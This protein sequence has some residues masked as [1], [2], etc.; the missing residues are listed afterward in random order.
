MNSCVV[1]DIAAITLEGKRR[2]NQSFSPLSVGKKWF[3][4]EVQKR[5]KHFETFKGYETKEMRDRLGLKK[6]SNKLSSDFS[7]HCVD[8]FVLANEMVGGDIIDN[9]E[10][11]CITPLI[12]ER[13]NLH[14]EKPHKKPNPKGIRWRYG[15]TMALGYKKGT[16]VKSI[17]H[18][19]CW[20]SGHQD[21]KINLTKIV[22]GKK[23]Q[24]STQRQE[25]FRVLKRLKFFWESI[26]GGTQTSQS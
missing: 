5:V 15:G 23:K 21:G 10:V 1:E 8:S 14:R 4:R 18:G 11:F 2:W 3:Y 13:R 25:T 12:T 16:L 19:L 22:N 17:K 26:S 24:I 9:T 20:I 6:S 7:A